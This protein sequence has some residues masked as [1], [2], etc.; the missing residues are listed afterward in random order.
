VEVK[1]CRNCGST[2]IEVDAILQEQPDGR[3]I[4][5]EICKIICA[6]CGTPASLSPALTIALMHHLIEKK[7]AGQGEAIDGYLR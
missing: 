1:G 4:G 3:W 2:Q 5:E 6:Q 7:E